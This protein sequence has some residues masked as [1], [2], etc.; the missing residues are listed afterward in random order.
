M[1][2]EFIMPMHEI[3]LHLI[4]SAYQKSSYTSVVCHTWQA[5]HILRPDVTYPSPAE[6]SSFNFL[7]P[8]ISKPFDW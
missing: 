3:T 7:P 1:L 2:D 5:L 4:A 6:I 8:D